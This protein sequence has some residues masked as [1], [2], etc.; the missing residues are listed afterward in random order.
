MLISVL[1]SFNRISN[2]GMIRSIKS[3]FYTNNCYNNVVEE[4]IIYYVSIKL[5]LYYFKAAT[6]ALKKRYVCCINENMY[7]SWLLEITWKRFC[8]IQNAA[9]ARFESC[10]DCCCLLDQYRLKYQHCLEKG[11]AVTKPL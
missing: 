9:S 3:L 11:N 10:G 7:I 4:W 6:E 2:L 5:L 1:Y 8:I